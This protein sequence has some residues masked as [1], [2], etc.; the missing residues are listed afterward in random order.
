VKKTQFSVEQI[1]A[2]L[3]QTAAGVPLGDVCRQVGV[4]QHTFYRWR[5]PH[6]L[7]AAD[8]PYRRR[9]V[10]LSRSLHEPP[11]AE[12]GRSYCPHRPEEPRQE[13]PLSRQ[14]SLKARWLNRARVPDQDALSKVTDHE[15]SGSSCE[16]SHTAATRQSSTGILRLTTALCGERRRIAKP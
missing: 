6:R 15:P 4:S 11:A 16:T 5:R 7:A 10:H 12:G 13:Q 2:V 3:Q 9:S 8:G 1:T 14:I